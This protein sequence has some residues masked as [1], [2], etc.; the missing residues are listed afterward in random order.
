MPEMLR[1]LSMLQVDVFNLYND[2][3]KEEKDGDK[4]V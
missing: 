1:E 2:W 3:K 4:N